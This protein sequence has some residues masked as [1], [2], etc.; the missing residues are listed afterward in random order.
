MHVPTLPRMLVNQAFYICQR[1]LQAVAYEFIS[2]VYGPISSSG[3]RASH[4]FVHFV[5]LI[6]IEYT[7]SLSLFHPA[8]SWA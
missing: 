5:W 3:V 4:C 6:K 1:F 7:D 2:H 8:I